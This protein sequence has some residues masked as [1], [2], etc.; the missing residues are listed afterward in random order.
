MICTHKILLEAKYKPTE[1]T[2]VQNF[3]DPIL[4]LMVHK[5]TNDS[6]AE[7]DSTYGLTI[8]EL[9]DDRQN[10]K[11]TVGDRRERVHRKGI[12][13]HHTKYIPPPLRHAQK[14]IEE[15]DTFH[16][17]IHSAPHMHMGHQVTPPPFDPG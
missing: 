8:E 16:R 1:K 15:K 7:K 3:Y 2:E 13:V 9:S 10:F 12:S 4:E 6:Q 5:E 14:R 11:A 17:P